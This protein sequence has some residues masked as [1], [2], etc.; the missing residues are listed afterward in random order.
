[1]N[2]YI[3]LIKNYAQSQRELKEKKYRLTKRWEKLKKLEAKIAKKEEILLAQES[4]KKLVLSQVKKSQSLALK[5][6]SQINLVN[7]WGLIMNMSQSELLALVNQTSENK[8]LNTGLNA[9]LA[10]TILKGIE[11]GFLS[12]IDLALNR[13]I[14]PVKQKV[15]H[16]G[17]LKLADIVLE[18]NK[19][20]E[21]SE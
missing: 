11:G 17:E 7:A 1:M 4:E 6:L 15:E 3:Q 13:V 12:Q 14:G 8:D 10:A 9:A 21:K 19:I 18:A 5:Q 16:S 20:E 2:F